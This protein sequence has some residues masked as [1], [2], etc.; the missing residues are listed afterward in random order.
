[1]RIIS[2]TFFIALFSIL[3]IANQANNLPFY[4]D[5]KGI[6]FF[7]GLTLIIS[8]ATANATVTYE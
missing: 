8:G 7:T 3:I 1:M 2:F 6:P 5:L 4:I